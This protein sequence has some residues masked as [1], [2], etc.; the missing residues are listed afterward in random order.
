MRQSKLLFAAVITALLTLRAAAQSAN[1]PATALENFERQTN[2]LIIRGYSLVGS[3]TLGNDSLSVHTQAANDVTHGQKKYG[4]TVDLNG[5]TASGA[6]GRLSLAAD[7]DELDSLSGS[8]D[9]LGKITWGA[10]PLNSFE[11]GYTTKSGLRFSAHSSHRN[12]AI[13]YYV[14]LGDYPKISLSSDQ[15]NQL[16]NLIVQAKSALDALK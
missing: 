2:T 5:K 16:K 6:R 10:T 13:N 7:Y 12:S 8:L 1:P 4:I 15:L 14:Q 9:Y 3:I 11:A